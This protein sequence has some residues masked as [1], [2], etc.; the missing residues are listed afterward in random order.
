M[1]SA[2]GKP[3]E[4]L[5]PEFAGAGADLMPAFEQGPW[6]WHISSG[7]LAGD[8]TLPFLL[9]LGAGLEDYT[10]GVDQMIRIPVRE[11]GAYDAGMVPD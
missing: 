7:M 9:P 11:N 2:T 6:R 10:V 8:D 5:G 4:A 3:L 1:L